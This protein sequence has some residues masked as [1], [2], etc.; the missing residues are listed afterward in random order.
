MITSPLT[1]TLVP[2]T[3]AYF[4][5]GL[6][7]GLLPTASSGSVQVFFAEFIWIDFFSRSPFYVNQHPF[8]RIFQSTMVAFV[9]KYYVLIRWI[10]ATACMTPVLGR[11]QTL[12]HVFNAQL[13]F[14]DTSIP[15]FWSQY[16]C[17]SKWYFYQLDWRPMCYQY[18]LGSYPVRTPVVFLNAFS[19]PSR[20]VYKQQLM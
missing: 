17:P 8:W 14:L 3:A 12:R 11:I 20:P 9:A 10:F 13:I 19:F 16:F 4:F 15:N 6:F 5:Q 2:W 18:N 1:I 7:P